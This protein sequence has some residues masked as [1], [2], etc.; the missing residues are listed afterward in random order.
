MWFVRRQI[1]R[2]GMKKKNTI[3]VSTITMRVHLQSQKHCHNRIFKSQARQLSLGT[4][5]FV[6]WADLSQLISVLHST[7]RKGKI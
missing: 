5:R 1:N 2:F 3:D 7:V 6:G 4:E